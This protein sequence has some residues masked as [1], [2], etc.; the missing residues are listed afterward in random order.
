MKT[1]KG[2]QRRERNVNAEPFQLNGNRN[3]VFLLPLSGKPTLQFPNMDA[4][5]RFHPPAFAHLLRPWRRL[6]WM[7][8]RSKA[9][10]EAV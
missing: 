5:A 8:V 7:A 3:N 1:R 2:R 10:F 6:R 4:M 9:D